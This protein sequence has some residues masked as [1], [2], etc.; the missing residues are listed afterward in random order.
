[1]NSLESIRQ[2]ISW[3]LCTFSKQIVFP[4]LF[5]IQIHIEKMEFIL[6][7]DLLIN[8]FSIPLVFASTFTLFNN[9]FALLFDF[10]FNCP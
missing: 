4:F 8:F 10:F 3:T 7:S 2:S 1:M 6:K 9:F 5:L